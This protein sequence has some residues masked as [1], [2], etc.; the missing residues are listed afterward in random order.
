[1][2]CQFILK[3]YS[4][5]NQNFECDTFASSIS[6]TKSEILSFFINQVTSPFQNYGNEITEKTS[7]EFTVRGRIS[8]I[9]WSQKSG[10]LSKKQGQTN[11]RFLSPGF[12]L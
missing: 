8:N 5:R 10:H 2:K 1:M 3:N 7:A 12:I 11:A 6:Y 4:L 9:F